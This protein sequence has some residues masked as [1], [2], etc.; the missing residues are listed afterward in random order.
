MFPRVVAHNGVMIPAV[1]ELLDSA[2]VVALPMQTRFRGV[3][4]REALL[5]EGPEGWAEFS[6]SSNTTTPRRRPGWPPRSTTPTPA[7]RSAAGSGGRQRHG[8][9]RRRRS[10][11]RGPGALLRMPDRE[12][13]GR[14]ARAGAGGRRRPG[15]RRPGD[16]RAGGPHPD[17][18][19]RPVERRRGRARRPRARRVRPGVR[20]AAVRLGARARRAATADRLHGHPGRGG[21]EHPEVRRPPRRGARG[22]RGHRRH[23]SAAAGRDHPRAADRHRGRPARGRLQRAGH[24][25]RALAGAALAA[26]LPTLDYDCGLGTASLFQD[27]V[28]DLRPAD[29]AIPV[30]RLSPDPT[31]LTRLAAAD[32]RR[33]WWLARLAR[34]H[35]E[36]L[37]NRSA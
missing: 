9:G 34:C 6:P 29:G 36:L 23:Q 7:T 17:R 11:A 37:G 15:P 12:G 4:T 24:R 20:R 30:G 19:Q 33:E 27:D 13:Q 26:A 25:D 14:R 2:R 10:R 21:R 31:A 18:R 28:A 16:S 32:E 35:H 8:A 1:T 5:F 3:D 22:S